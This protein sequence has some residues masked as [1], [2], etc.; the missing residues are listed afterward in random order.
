MNTISDRPV[1]TQLGNTKKFLLV[2]DY[3]YEWS[4]EGTLFRITV[5]AGFVTDMASSPRAVWWLVSP[6]DLG[7]APLTHDWLYHWGGN[8]PVGSYQW[9]SAA[10]HVWVD[11]RHVWSR[12][13]ADRLFGRGMREH[14]VARWRRRM[15]FR[16]VDVLGRSH[17]RA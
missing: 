3:T 1:L 11:A 17:W 13:D 10:L 5:P 7:G 12:Y 6:F 2:E 14:G 16:I 15:A 8:L 9:Y 4:H